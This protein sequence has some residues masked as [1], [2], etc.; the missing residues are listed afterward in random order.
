MVQKVGFAMLRARGI[1]LIARHA[2]CAPYPAGPRAVSEFEKAML[3][4]KQRMRVIASG[5]L[6]QRLRAANQ[7]L[8]R[9]LRQSNSPASSPRARPKGGKRS[10]REIQQLSRRQVM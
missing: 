9:S 6:A 4:A 2:Y 5:A 8:S 1:D 3:V 10:L 7:L